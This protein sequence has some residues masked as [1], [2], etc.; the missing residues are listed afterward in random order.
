MFILRSSEAGRSCDGIAKLVADSTLKM[1]GS[2]SSSGMPSSSAIRCAETAGS[3][4]VLR[5]MMRSSVMFTAVAREN[6]GGSGGLAGGGDGDGTSSVTTAGGC[7]LST[8]MPSS[9]D[10]S[11]VF[12]AWK[13]TTAAWAGSGLE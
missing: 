9:L 4:G 13:L 12:M 3:N 2:S 10:S 8:V 1:R 5:L 11:A 6:P 7:A